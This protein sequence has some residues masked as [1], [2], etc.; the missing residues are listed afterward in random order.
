MHVQAAQKKDGTVRRGH[1]ARRSPPRDLAVAPLAAGSRLVTRWLPGRRRTPR[2]AGRAAHAR[3]V[4]TQCLG[5]YAND[6]A[7]VAWA[8]ANRIALSS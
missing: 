5:A 6:T 4:T 1:G 2:G 3:A 7:V 8:S